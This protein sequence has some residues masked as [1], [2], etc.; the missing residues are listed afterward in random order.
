[1]KTIINYNQI[2]I[3]R[4]LLAGG[5]VFEQTKLS[6]DFPKSVQVLTNF[7]S[8]FDVLYLRQTKMIPYM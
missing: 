2:Y 5:L 4:V 6:F 7:E 1:M 8:R 3:K